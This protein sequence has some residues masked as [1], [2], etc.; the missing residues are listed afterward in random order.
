MK[1]FVYDS[2]VLC[3]SYFE[4]LNF[5]FAIVHNNMELLS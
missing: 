4:F 5:D 1:P 3:I 2:S